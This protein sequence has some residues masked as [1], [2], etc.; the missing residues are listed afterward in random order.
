MMTDATAFSN[1]S[2]D[3]L[4]RIFGSCNLAVIVSVYILGYQNVNQ[5]E[6]ASNGLFLKKDSRPVPYN[7]RLT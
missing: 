3:D 1:A 4:Q 2:S 7:L 5:K 6:M